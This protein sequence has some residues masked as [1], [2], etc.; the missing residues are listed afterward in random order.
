MSMTFATD[1]IINNGYKLNDA[2]IFY[3]TIGS[4]STD[5]SA[6]TK[7]VVC[8]NFKSTDLVKGVALFVNVGITNTGAVD[9]LKFNVNSTGEKV[10]KCLLNGTL[11]NL[12]AA[13]YLLGNETYLFFYDGTSWVTTVNRDNDSSVKTR[14]TLQTGDALRPILLSY[15][16]TSST[17]GNVDNITYRNNTI[18]ANPATGQIYSKS[19]PVLIGEY[20]ASSAPSSPVTGQLWLKDVGMS[21]EEAKVLIVSTGT[22]SSLPTT[23]TDSNIKEDMVVINKYD[24]VGDLSMQGSDLTVITT[25]GSATISGTLNGSTNITLYLMRAR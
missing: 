3:G 9:S 13:S 17:T 19:K 7:T 24:A 14:Q 18:Y 1:V 11:A 21:I 22:I 15:A 23:I 6:T 12:P 4:T 8:S 2:R 25:D 10:V 20:S 5:A 16:Q